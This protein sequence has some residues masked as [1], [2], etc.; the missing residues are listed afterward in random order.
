MVRK[1]TTNKSAAKK[2][3]A[4]KHAR[5]GWRSRL[6]A[7]CQGCDAQGAAGQDPGQAVRARRLGQGRPGEEGAGKKAPVA[8][9]AAGRAQGPGVSQAAGRQGL[10]KAPAATRI[11]A[12][13]GAAAAKPLHAQGGGPQ[14]GDRSRSSGGSRRGVR[15][16]AGSHAQARRPGD[17]R[18]GCGSP[19][20][21]RRTR[22]RWRGSRRRLPTRSRCTSGTASRPTSGSS[23][24]PTASAASSASRSRRSPACRSSS[25]SSPSRRTR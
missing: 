15:S 1:A 20:G 24:R 25:S 3:D 14:G 18:R 16:D 4:R 8:A 17:H 11:V 9:K 23:I 12:R 7:V 6:F 5:Q 19:Q 21:G 10:A 13:Q 22:P 2:A